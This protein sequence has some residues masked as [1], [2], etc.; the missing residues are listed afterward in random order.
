MFLE[1]FKDKQPD[2]ALYTRAKC[3]MTS[4]NAAASADPSLFMQFIRACFFRKNS[5]EIPLGRQGKRNHDICGS[6]LDWSSE[7]LQEYGLE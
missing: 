5:T 6:K 3:G 4:L 7:V 2:S 1:I